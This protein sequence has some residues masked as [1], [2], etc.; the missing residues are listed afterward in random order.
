MRW[1]DDV[2]EGRCALAMLAGP[3]ESARPLLDEPPLL[4]Y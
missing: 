3:E 2:F 4:A 1:V